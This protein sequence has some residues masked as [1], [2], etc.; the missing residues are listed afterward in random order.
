VLTGSAAEDHADTQGTHYTILASGPV[1][2]DLLP[3]W[4]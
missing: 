3:A 1:V 4:P 2:A